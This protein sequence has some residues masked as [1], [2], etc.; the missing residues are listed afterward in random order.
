MHSS[1]SRPC[2]DCLPLVKRV[3]E[4]DQFNVHILIGRKMT[5]V[6][7]EQ[8]IRPMPKAKWECD[9][10]IGFVADR[11]STFAA[12]YGGL[13]LTPDFQRGHVWTEE[14]QIRF[15]ESLIRNNLPSSALLLQ[16]NAPH[17]D[18]FTT[19]LGKLPK[20]LQCVDGLQRITAIRS[21]LSGK[22]EIFGGLR[23]S[24][25]DGT[26]FGMDRVNYR[27]RIAIHAFQ[28]RAELLQYYLDLNAGGTPHSQEEIERV[29]QLLLSANTQP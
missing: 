6:E 7:L 23:K 26:R 2:L 24:D 15:I 3:Q 17:F 5:N 29:R 8:I 4:Q 27:V 21:F 22:L 13:N 16:F 12:D 18:E 19:Y 20:E 11:L 9:Y 28:T 10:P 1:L 14:Q 25:L